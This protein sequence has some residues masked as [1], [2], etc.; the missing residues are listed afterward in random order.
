MHYKLR[1]FYFQ[2]TF[3]MNFDFIKTSKSFLH[4][5]THMNTHFMRVYTYVYLYTRETVNYFHQHIEIVL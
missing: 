3:K 5:K 4:N 2:K 1:V